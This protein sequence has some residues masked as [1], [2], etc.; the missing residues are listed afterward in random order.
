MIIIIKNTITYN[1]GSK[2]DYRLYKY[3]KIFSK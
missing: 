3:K 1:N 2:F